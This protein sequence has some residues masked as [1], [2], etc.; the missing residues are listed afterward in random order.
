MRRVESWSSAIRELKCGSSSDTS[1]VWSMAPATSSSLPA[2]AR[3]TIGVSSRHRRPNKLRSSADASASLILASSGPN[4]A[5]ALTRLVNQSP[6]LSSR[7]AG[8]PWRCSFSADM[9]AITFFMARAAS[10]RT[11]VSSHPA[12]EASK[13]S[14]NPACSGPPMASTSSASDFAIARRTS[15]SSSTLSRSR[16]SKVV[17]ACSG[18]ITFATTPMR[19]MASI[20]R[21]I[22]SFLSSSFIRPRAIVAASAMVER[23]Q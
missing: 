7:A 17:R 3:R 6:V 4:S 12:T 14:N 2:A 20:R 19:R 15:S 5:V 16:S 8:M 9:S 10:S 18:P 1:A 22:S 13:G 11:T 23:Q 21:S